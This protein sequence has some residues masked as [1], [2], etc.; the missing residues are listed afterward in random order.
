MSENRADRQAEQQRVHKVMDTIRASIDQF[1]LRTGDIKEQVVDIRK[2]FWDEVTIDR[3]STDD[4][5]ETYISVKQQAE[6]LSERERSHRHAA[7]QIAKLRRLQQS[8]YFGRI[9]FRENGSNEDDIVYLGVASLLDETGDRFLVYDWRAP[10]SSLYY[11]YGPGPAEYET[12]SG[13]IA[14]NLELKRQFVIKGGEL[15]LMFDTGITIGDEILQQVLGK[16]ADAQM[17]NIVATIQREQNRII[18]NDQNRLLIVSGPAGSGKTSAA[19]QRVAY[20]LYKYR[21]MLSADQIVLFSP[22]PMFNRYVSTVLPELGEENM[23]QTTFQD[24]LEHR[25]SQAFQVEDPFTQME[26]VLTAENEPGYEARIQSIAFKSSAAFLDMIRSYRTELESRG[27]VFKD[28]KLRGRILIPASDISNKFYS[29]TST[30]KL[31]PRIHVVVE[32][33]LERLESIMQAERNKPWVQEEVE[34]LEPEDYQKAF[35]QLRRE[36]RMREGAFNEG[37]RES[38]LLRELVIGR[39]TK[40]LASRVQKLRF[41]DLPSTY[42]QLFADS[43]TLLG[44]VGET[45]AP[46]LLRDICKLTVERLDRGE[47]AYEDATPYLYLQEL[48]EGFQI[49]MNILHVFVDEAQDY[50]PF[51]YEFLKK[52]FPRS[53]MTVLGDLNQAIYAHSALPAFEVLTDLYGEASTETIALTR[54]YR[55]TR[56]IVEFTRG[57]L[58]DGGRIEPFNRDGQKPTV[59]AAEDKA[60]LHAHI[61]DR[62]KALQTDGFRTTAIICK[63]AKES[64]EAFAALSALTDISLRLI[65]KDSA[66][67]ESGV[68]IIPSY[69]A[70]G[71]EFDAVIIYD[72]SKHAYGREHERKLFYTACTRAMHRLDVYCLGE[73]SPFIA[74]TDPR[75]YTALPYTGTAGQVAAK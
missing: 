15:E 26:Y 29:I 50:T 36:R 49:N 34:L 63:T 54:T 37:Q 24:Y 35:K 9:D 47:L 58:A 64:A 31:T 10:I 67:F 28:I 59:T 51:Q 19:L 18:R 61:A 21:Q 60:G 2:H 45:A 42:R 62:L 4:I 66:A 12:P 8:P 5:V 33:L 65:S 6:L 43:D 3:G 11:D 72:G 16:G 68:V 7:Q 22:N 40:R 30:T 14:G 70:K 25:L 74:G 46:P 52:L 69:L 48:V 73:P 75:T 38:D 20:L 41:I 32:W 1:S 56:P 55:S 39:H 13:K 23:E 53:R 17:K 71:I 27:L 57:M 44:I